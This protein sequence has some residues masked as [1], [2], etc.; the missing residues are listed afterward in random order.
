MTAVG[1]VR[2]M[3]IV[4]EEKGSSIGDDGVLESHWTDFAF[5]FEWDI[6]VGAG[7]GSLGDQLKALQ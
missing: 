7:G 6:G 5:Y 1:W 3:F 2:T 4:M